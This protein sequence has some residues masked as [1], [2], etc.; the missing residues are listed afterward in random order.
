MHGEYVLEII[1]EFVGK[2]EWLIF[3]DR[4]CVAFQD[5]ELIVL[6]SNQDNPQLILIVPPKKILVIKLY[7]DYFTSLITLT[8]YF[9][10]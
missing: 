8:Y 10:S 5:K 3:S 7:L 6:K 9:V 1:Y 4:T 2:E